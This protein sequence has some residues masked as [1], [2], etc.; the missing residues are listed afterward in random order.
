MILYLTSNDHVNLLDFTGMTHKKMVGSFMLKQFVIHDMRS[1]SHCTHLILDR[2]AISE[3]DTSFTLAIEEFLTM[4][5]ARVTVIFEGLSQ[6]SELFK[7]LLSIGVCNI[8]TAT[9]ISEIQ[10]EISECLS[11]EGM[12][13][14]TS[15]ESIKSKNEKETYRFNCKN[16]RIAVL[17]SQ[18]RTGATT[19]AVSLTAWL[20]AVGAAACY[21]EVNTSKHLSMLAKVYEMQENNG[22]YT[23]D[24]VDYYSVP[25]PQK[26]YNFI[27]YD[28]GRDYQLND[29]M[30]GK[31]DILII[32]CGTKPYELPYTQRILAVFEE[33]CAFILCPFVEEQLKDTYTAYLKSEFHMLLFMEYQPELF[34]G[35][36]NKKQFE[37]VI[38]KYIGEDLSLRLA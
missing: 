23:L 31:A 8:V 34:D 36:K 7:G 13:R 9:D 26:D 11:D 4:Y 1:F 30:V 10:R 24:G 12:T 19:V 5:T 15:N 33:S 14:Y 6:Q 18:S 37:S 28:I 27:I 22:H 35:K 2:I 25:I 16:I 21:V 38:Q 32:C 3:D 29:E 20:N 17:S